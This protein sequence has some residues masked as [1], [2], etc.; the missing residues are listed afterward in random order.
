MLEIY[1]GCKSWIQL[2]NEID[3]NGAG[4]VLSDTAFARRL[5]E[6]REA[7]ELTAAAGTE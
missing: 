4:Q 3:I 2:E 6:F 5:T 7:L 1:G